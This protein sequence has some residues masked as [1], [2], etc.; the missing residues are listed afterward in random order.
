[1]KFTKQIFQ[2]RYNL[3]EKH[4]CLLY[5]CFLFE[6]KH[7]TEAKFK[8]MLSSLR[9]DVLQK[10]RKTYHCD[11]TD[12]WFD[13][14][15]MTDILYEVCDSL[16]IADISFENMIKYTNLFVNKNRNYCINYIFGNFI[17]PVLSN[18]QGASYETRML[19]SLG[20]ENIKGISYEEVESQ[21]SDGYCCRDCDGCLG[22]YK[23]SRYEHHY[24][25]DAKKEINE[26]VEKFLISK[27]HDHERS[28]PQPDFKIFS[29]C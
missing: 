24:F 3:D 5:A 26:T 1:M 22:E 16:V 28:I 19:E 9:Q 7:I 15:R 21:L 25:R 10:R 8:G 2:Y 27:R 14:M 17:K 11:I 4:S 18:Y 29:R 20:I 23:R 6:S 13:D 12:E